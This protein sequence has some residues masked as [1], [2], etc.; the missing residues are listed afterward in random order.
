MTGR[1]ST[2]FGF[3]FTPFYKTGVTI[4]R[5]MEELQPSE[6]PL[7]LDEANA[8]TMKPIGELALSLSLSLPVSLIPHPTPP[9][10][11]HAPLF[12]FSKL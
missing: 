8:A 12:L 9:P 3:E 4:F 10:P 1:Y 5:W 2:R 7:F 6:I 11:R